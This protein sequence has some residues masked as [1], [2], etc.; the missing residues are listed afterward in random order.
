VRLQDK[1]AGSVVSSGETYIEFCEHG[2]PPKDCVTCRLEAD[3]PY[4]LVPEDFEALLVNGVP[5]TEYI[6][7][8]YIPKGARVWFWGPTGT[9]KS[10]YAMW[11]GATL[12]REGLTVAYFSEENPLEEDLRRIALLKPDAKFFRWFPR[13]GL[14]LTDSE[15]IAHML[16]ATTECDVAIFDTWTD[17]WYGD[18]NSNPEVRDFDARVLKPLQAQGCTPIVIH[19]T[20]HGQPNTTPRQA[21]SAGRGASTLGQKADVTLHFKPEANADGDDAFQLVYGKARI[22]GERPGPK[23]FRVVGGNDEGYLDIVE[24]EGQ[25]TR[26]VLAM[27]GDMKRYI[28]NAE[29]GYLT[30]G[31]L[32][33]DAGGSTSVATEAMELLKEDSDI[34]YTPNDKVLAASGKYHVSKTWRPATARLV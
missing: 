26:S 20:G 21:A 3:D 28:C 30:T 27:T 15:W 32:R 11:L 7:K 9:A 8:P 14:D 25:H 34:I 6:Y 5:E 13:R 17:S 1:V 31:E 24:I 23:S 19:H 33:A 29:K 22:G 10:M 12:S 16:E 18:E 2:N 4:A